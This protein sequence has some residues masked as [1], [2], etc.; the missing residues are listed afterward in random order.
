MAHTAHTV[1][2]ADMAMFAEWKRRWI[3]GGNCFCAVPRVPQWHPGD[4]KEDRFL[5]LPTALCLSLM[6]RKS[7]KEKE[8]TAKPA[9]F[10]ALLLN[11][12]T[13][14]EGEDFLDFSY[15]EESALKAVLPNCQGVLLASCGVMK[16]AVGQEV[17]FMVFRSLQGQ[18]FKVAMRRQ[19][20][21]ILCVILLAPA[22]DSLAQFLVDEALALV[23]LRHGRFASVSDFR[24]L[25]P[26]FKA[27][28]ALA[29]EARSRPTP[30]PLLGLM[31]WHPLASDWRQVIEQRVEE[32]EKGWKETAVRPMAVPQ[33]FALLLEQQ[34]MATSL[35]DE[36]FSACMRLLA[37]E[38]AEPSPASNDFDVRCHSLFLNPSGDEPLPSHQYSLLQ[39]GKW[40]LFLLWNMTDIEAE[41]SAPPTPPFRAASDPFGID[42]SLELLSK[43]P[44]PRPSSS[45]GPEFSPP[46]R[47]T[48]TGHEKN[49]RGSFGLTC[50]F[51]AR[52]KSSELTEKVSRPASFCYVLDVP[53]AQSSS[54]SS[55]SQLQEPKQISS[56]QLPE[57]LRCPVLAGQ[58]KGRRSFE[59]T[60][61]EFGD[62]LEELGDLAWLWRTYSERRSAWRQ[63]PDTASKRH[64]LVDILRGDHSLE[65]I[66]NE[67][68]AGSELCKDLGPEPED[69]L[70][71]GKKTEATLMGSGEPWRFQDGSPYLASDLTE[72]I[73][74]GTKRAD[75]WLAGS[76][77]R[78]MESVAPPARPQVATSLS[79]HRVF[80]AMTEQQ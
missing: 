33:G 40:L 74:V 16:A 28:S 60:N 39:K 37:L 53:G 15:P 63:G 2:M 73:S 58:A 9:E 32:W 80:L 75:A 25:E 47:S 41:T 61:A 65:K 70:K 48:P 59:W 67:S 55:F 69:P 78:S 68:L 6:P 50:M 21:W 18:E 8:L 12:T 19:E 62:F 10:F 38:A 64:V 14:D 66:W 3:A 30:Y 23:L 44:E 71:G 77:C 4:G 51:K 24:Q 52:T 27:L 45:P 1:Y 31:Q 26:I 34:V 72:L 46:A 11:T 43:L 20:R 13:K 29:S 79:G 42:L 54:S 57:G 76:A 17:N 49:K 7:V 56:S 36:T 5:N 35:D 22:T